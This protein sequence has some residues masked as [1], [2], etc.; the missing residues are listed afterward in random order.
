M[1]ISV[2]YPLD[3]DSNNEVEL[4]DVEEATAYFDSRIK[5]IL[6]PFL[7]LNEL[8]FF[9]E[10]RVGFKTIL[11]EFPSIYFPCKM[12]ASRFG[13][14]GTGVFHEHT[15][16][17]YTTKPL[18][19]VHGSFKLKLGFVSIYYTIF[20]LYYSYLCGKVKCIFSSSI[21]RKYNEYQHQFRFRHVK[22]RD[23]FSSF[24]CLSV[25]QFDC[26]TA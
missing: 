17:N 6:G 4:K 5:K 2:F 18:V 24:V 23:I 13:G 19:V 7:I 11:K 1:K 9:A 15:A 26:F 3:V 21:Q 22:A 25:S 10:T 16:T 14:I 20:I 12:S 8:G